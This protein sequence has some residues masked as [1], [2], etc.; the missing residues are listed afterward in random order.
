MIENGRNRRFG[1]TFL[2]IALTLVVTAGGLAWF[3]RPAGGGDDRTVRPS[4]SIAP[5][6]R[7]AFAPCPLA[8]PSGG[9]EERGVGIAAE[10]YLV[11]IERQRRAFEE[12]FVPHDQGEDQ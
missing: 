4:G 6:E 7:I 12:M 8:V 11:Q 1:R 5:E 3:L 10:S 2:V 9:P